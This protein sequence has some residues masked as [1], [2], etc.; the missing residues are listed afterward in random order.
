M[1]ASI[2]TITYEMWRHLATQREEDGTNQGLDMP[3]VSP[4]PFRSEVRERLA[5]RNAIHAGDAKLLAQ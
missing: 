1:L 4:G 5:A 2:S 3:T